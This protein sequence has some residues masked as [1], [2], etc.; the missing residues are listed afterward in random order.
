MF[1]RASPNPGSVPADGNGVP[2]GAAPL[3]RR[4]PRLRGARADGAR[5]RARSGRCARL[6]G[7][8]ARLDL[9]RRARA[10]HHARRPGSAPIR[11]APS[12][13]CSR[14]GRVFEYWA[15]EA[16]LLPIEDYPLFKR[17]MVHLRDHHWWGR[18]RDMQDVERLVLE[19]IAAEGAAPLAR[20]RGEEDERTT[21]GRGS[22]R[23]ARSSTCSRRASCASPGGTASSASTSCRSGSIPKALLE[24]PAPSEEEFARAVRAARGR[25]RGAR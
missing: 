2:G 7:R 15:H 25:G 20:V 13:S 21:C 16:C 12:R 8:P 3:R 1:R 22:R 14:P 5:G 23:S 11:A 24:A 4:A 18:P 6:R 17:R 19:R 10:P 9:D